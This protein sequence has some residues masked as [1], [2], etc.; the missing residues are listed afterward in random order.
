MVFG[1]VE[2]NDEIFV[3]LE[4]L[5]HGDD[6]FVAAERG[7]QVDFQ[8]HH[9]PV[10]FRPFRHL[11]ERVRI[12]HFI[13]TSLVAVTILSGFRAS[14]KLNSQ[15]SDFSNNLCSATNNF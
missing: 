2:D 4:P 5:A 15:I 1:P 13:V 10:D 14:E 8:R 3:V 11:R 7:Q 12:T 6:V 9:S